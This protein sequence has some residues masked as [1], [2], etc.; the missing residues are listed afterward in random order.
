MT[1]RG[2][3]RKERFSARRCPGEEEER[4]NAAST[5]TR[6]VE[7]GG[8]VEC[9]IDPV[10]VL[11]PS[12][13]RRQLS[14]GAELRSVRLASA[15]QTILQ[16][17]LFVATHGSTEDIRSK[18]NEELKAWITAQDKL[19]KSPPNSIKER[20]KVLNLIKFM[21]KLSNQD[22]WNKSFDKLVKYHS[23]HNNCVVPFNVPHLGEWVNNQR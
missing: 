6:R 18:A 2:E 13:L 20:I 3:R 14:D 9:R 5:L 22:K 19:C 7:N 11:L 15:Q 10:V 12:P 4:N 17:H 16:F 21:W 1:S 23:I 8:G